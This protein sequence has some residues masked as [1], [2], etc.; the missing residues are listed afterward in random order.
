MYKKLSREEEK[1]I[2][3]GMD[4]S[5]PPPSTGKT[6]RTF[7]FIGVVFVVFVIIAYMIISAGATA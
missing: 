1:M 4:N 3:E 7:L 2:R 5:S 6:I